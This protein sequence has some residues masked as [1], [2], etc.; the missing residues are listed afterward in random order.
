MTWYILQSSNGAFVAVQWG[1][2]SDDA[3][4]STAPDFDGDGKTDI[5]VWRPS[6]GTWYITLSSTSAI[7]TQT[8]GTSGDVPVS[9]AYLP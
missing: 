1:L 5:A 3:Q 7:K 9:S 2:N 6:N 4:T 8:I